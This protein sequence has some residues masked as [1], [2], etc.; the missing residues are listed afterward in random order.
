MKCRWH[1]DSV[2]IRHNGRLN[3]GIGFLGDVALPMEMEDDVEAVVADSPQEK[4]ETGTEK[5]QLRGWNEGPGRRPCQDVSYYPAINLAKCWVLRSVY[6]V[7]RLR[8]L[9]FDAA[10]WLPASVTSLLQVAL[11]T[12]LHQ[13]ERARARGRKIE[14]ESI[15]LLLLLLS[16][17]WSCCWP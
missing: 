17:G 12:R 3:F 6:P 11:K 2:L 1:R 15:S 8:R 9:R 10:D 4:N 16:V 13:K 7:L 14:R 5:I